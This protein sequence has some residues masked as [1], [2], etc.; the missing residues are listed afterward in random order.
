MSDIKS[1]SLAQMAE[2]AKGFDDVWM[3]NYISHNLAVARFLKPTLLKEAQLDR[4]PMIFNEMRILIIRKGWTNPSIN[5]IEHHFK[6]ND[7]V[8]M[9]SNG[10]FQLNSVSDNVQGFALSFTSELFYMATGNH[11]PTIF[12]GHLRE[13]HMS[14]K[15]DQLNYLDNIHD[16]LYQNV[17]SPNPNVQVC[18]SLISAFLW[19][20]DSIYEEN[21]KTGE[22]A[23]SREHQVFSDFI[24]LLGKYTPQKRNIE[25]YASKLFITPRYFGTLVKKVSGK[26]AKEWIDETVLTKIKI[27][28]RHSDKQV[29]RISE[30]MEFPNTSFFCKYFKKLTS[31]TPNEYRNGKTNMSAIKKSMKTLI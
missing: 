17:K 19:F 6:A 24:Q 9:G 25:F 30:E 1:F 8:F 15:S 7:L 16:L 26:T 13:F 23:L 4:E 28:L 14:L 18:I 27:E 10:L 29:S 22:P 2:F 31:I 5:L 3:K 12:D 11:P 21:E 20:I